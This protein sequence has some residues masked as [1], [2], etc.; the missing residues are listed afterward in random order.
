MSPSL[1][2]DTSFF[3]TGNTLSYDL[4][5]PF[6]P[7]WALSL[8]EFGNGAACIHSWVQVDDLKKK[9]DGVAFGMQVEQPFME[10]REV[11]YTVFSEDFKKAPVCP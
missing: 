1:L 11:E 3:V 4:G 7:G 10:A 2:E 8:D 6:N 9:P 5:T